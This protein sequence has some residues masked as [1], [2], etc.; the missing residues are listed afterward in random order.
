MDNWSLSLSLLLAGLV[1]GMLIS[2]AVAAVLQGLCEWLTLGSSVRRLGVLMLMLY[3]PILTAVWWNKLVEVT[4]MAIG[5][6][7]SGLVISIMIQTR[8]TRYPRLL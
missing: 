6:L 8:C 5:V 1:I 7:I 2:L 3:M 4:P